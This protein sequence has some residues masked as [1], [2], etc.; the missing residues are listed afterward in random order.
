MRHPTAGTD[1]RN[2]L[3]LAPAIALLIVSIGSI[4]AAT[5]SPSGTRGQYAV[6]APLWYNQTQT[7]ELVGIAGGDIVDLGGIANIVIAH[8]DNPGFTRSLYHAGAWLVI[9]PIGL[10][11]CLGIEQGFQRISGN[12]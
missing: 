4:F 8:S 7:I 5:V 12:V 11:G 2:W 1:S 10:R 6:V 3:D 9:D